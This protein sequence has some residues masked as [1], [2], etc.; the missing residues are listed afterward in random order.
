MD[1]RRDFFPE[2]V[3]A[4]GQDRGDAGPDVTPLYQGDMSHS[5]PRHVGDGVERPRRQNADDHAHLP[6]PAAGRL[7]GGGTADNQGEQGNGNQ[8]CD[9]ERL[10]HL[11]FHRVHL[12]ELL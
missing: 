4:V 7:R 1:G 2:Q 3:A 11:L 12:R 6:R 9:D 5:H 8:P 10:S